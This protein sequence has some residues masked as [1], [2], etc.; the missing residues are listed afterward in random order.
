MPEPMFR[1]VRVG[2]ARVL[3]ATVEEV[4][5]AIVAL[6]SQSQ[7]KVLTAYALHVGGINLIARGH[8][9]YV[10]GLI[11]ADVVYADGA[12]TVL[13]AKVGGARRIERAP[14]TDIGRPLLAAF[15][16]MLSRNVRV[17]LIGGPEGLAG[18][19]ARVLES[20][21]GVEVVHASAGY[22]TDD[23]ALARALHA[24]APDV[25]V[26]GMGAP[27]EVEW[28]ERMRP[29]LPPSVVITCGGWFGFL[30]GEERR[31]SVLLQKAHL[32]WAYRLSLAP[33]RLA[34]RYLL[35]AWNTLTLLPAQ[36]RMRRA[37]GLNAQHG[38]DEAG[39]LRTR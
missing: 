25:L 26:V 8:Q 10:N 39:R 24:A 27:I 28:V 37:A 4:V 16:S 34:A 30:A 2:P 14:T 33:R 12:A 18:R 15:A 32:E 11:S 29:S 35:G 38:R 17:A 21:G 20:E 22:H 7:R 9:G 36:R 13:L 31:A 5:S 6:D 23:D 3:D 1:T 19:A